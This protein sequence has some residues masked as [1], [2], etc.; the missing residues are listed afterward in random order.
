MPRRKVLFSA[1]VVL[2]LYLAMLSVLADAAV[3]KL[4]F[5]DYAAVILGVISVM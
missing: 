4:I 1:H 5:D 3:I 2:G